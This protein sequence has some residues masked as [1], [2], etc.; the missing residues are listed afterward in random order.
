M[1]PCL[2][3]REREVVKAVPVA[4]VLP[5]LGERGERAAKVCDG[6][7][8][9][10]V[11]HE[12]RT[13]M[14][15][16]RDIERVTAR[17]GEAN[18]LVN[19]SANG[20]MVAAL[21]CE[22]RPHLDDFHRLVELVSADR[23][24]PGVASALLGLMKA[25]ERRE[26]PRRLAQREGLDDQRGGLAGG[27]GTIQEREALAEPASLETDLCHG[28][29][30]R[31]HDVRRGPACEERFEG[32]TEISGISAQRRWG[33]WLFR[34][35]LAFWPWD[36]EPRARDPGEVGR[37]SASKPSRWI[38]AARDE[39]SCGVLLERL[40]Q[41]KPSLS[42]GRHD[43]NEAAIDKLGDQGE[44]SIARHVPTGGDRLNGAEFKGPDEHGQPAEQRLLC[45]G[46]QVIGPVD[47]S[48]KGALALDHATVG[49]GE[50]AES[51][52]EAALDLLG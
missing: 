16:S 6:L 7:I 2:E 15:C 36:P 14:E 40:S 37:V 34:H 35:G 4:L 18:A 24:L 1:G 19:R 27:E 21:V 32:G 39:S 20:L 46:E 28:C 13:L 30:E 52:L 9:V 50:E 10:L 26:Q 31:N 49:S 41:V 43:L 23:E 22:K 38:C 12:F 29:R 8:E 11:R 33:R 5:P 47:R 51:V 25:P 48:L 44:H 45:R 17:L 3:F 42:R